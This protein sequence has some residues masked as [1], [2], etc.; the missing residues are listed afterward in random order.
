MFHSLGFRKV[1]LF[2]AICKKSGNVCHLP[3][4]GIFKSRLV[5]GRPR[6]NETYFLLATEFRQVVL[7]Y[8]EANELKKN[9]QPF[10][11]VGYWQK[12]KKFFWK[13]VSPQLRHD[14]EQQFGTKEIRRAVVQRIIDEGGSEKKLRT[15]GTSKEVAY[16]NYYNK[17]HLR[18][19]RVETIRKR[20]FDIDVDDHV[21]RTPSKSPEMIVSDLEDSPCSSPKKMMSKKLKLQGVSYRFDIFSMG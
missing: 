18:A 16:G 13:C 7:D 2:L 19:L 10:K 3:R 1:P 5:E 11:D 21:L 17:L 8:I 9:D 15:I 6:I 12:M 14:A 4:F 20:K